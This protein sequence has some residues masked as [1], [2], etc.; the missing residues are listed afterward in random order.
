MDVLAHS[1]VRLTT[2]RLIGR[3]RRE[4]A[5]RSVAAASYAETN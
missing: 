1:A 3:D 2:Q 4:A 5:M